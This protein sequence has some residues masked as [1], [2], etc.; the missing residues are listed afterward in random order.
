[1]ATEELELRQKIAEAKAEERTYQ[2]FDEEQNID[3]MNDYL[4]DVKAKLTSTPFL[5]EAKR[6]S[7]TTLKV[8]SVKFQSS[9][10]VSTVT[11]TPPVTTPIFVSTAVMNPAAQ[12][13]VS[14]NTPIKEERRR[15]EYG[16]PTDTKPSCNSK[17]ECTYTFERD[18]SCVESARPDQ[19]YLG[20]QRKQAEL[21]QMI[22]TQQ[23]RSL[24]PSHEPPTFSGEVM[25]YPAFIAAF[26]T[27]IESKVDN[28]SERLYFLNQY[29][30]GKA[31]ELIK[32][33]LQMKSGDPY[34]E[35]RR[36]LKKH[37]GDP[38]KIASAYIAKL[39][40]WPAVRPNDG[41]ALQEFS[42]ALEQA[43][44]AMTGMQYMNDLNTANVL[45]QLW[46]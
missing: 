2:E 33:C 25:S 1:M 3:G 14:R 4:E 9:A 35:A 41:T 23:A 18:P 22:V 17:E 38:Y 40:N 29:T 45:R 11:T 39:S 37:F 21:S 10:F 28:S 8:P 44:N 5:T 42:I 30:S 24:L 19:D 31:K 12:P 26:E 27:L 6:N 7:Q 15:E 20:I 43:R 36:L 46:Q 16:T 32:G 34:K 13:F